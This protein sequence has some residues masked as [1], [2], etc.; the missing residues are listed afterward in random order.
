MPVVRVML[1]I[2]LPHWLY[3]PLRLAKRVLIDSRSVMSCGNNWNLVGIAFTLM[4]C[5]RQSNQVRHASIGQVDGHAYSDDWH[6]G[7]LSFTNS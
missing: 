7:T 4:T 2:Y 3:R 5:T 6:K 1:P